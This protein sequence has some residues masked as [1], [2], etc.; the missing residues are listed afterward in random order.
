M[1]RN[2]C[3]AARCGKS[4]WVGGS[5]SCGAPDSCNVGPVADAFIDVV[6]GAQPSGTVASLTACLGES[7]IPYRRRFRRPRRRPEAG[8]H[9][10]L[11]SL[12]FIF[13]TLPTKCLVNQKHETY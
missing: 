11:R 10:N 4:L 3:N 13:A 1:K 8:T 2:S 9:I 5:Y 12:I 7:E 6:I